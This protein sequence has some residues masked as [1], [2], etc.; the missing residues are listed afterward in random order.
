MSQK[1]LNEKNKIIE[2]LKEEVI[3][4]REKLKKTTPINKVEGTEKGLVFYVDKNKH[5]QLGKIRFDPET[6][7]AVLVSSENLGETFH[8]SSYK[9]REYFEKI[10][11]L[12][13]KE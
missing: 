2:D 11:L 10:I 6:S 12:G 13:G 1:E 3:S 7:S 4:L 9:A 8:L 5:F